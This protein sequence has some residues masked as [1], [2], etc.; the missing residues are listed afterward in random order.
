MTE[1]KIIP[2]VGFLFT[3]VINFA[4]QQNKVPLVRKLGIENRSDNDLADVQ[5][6]I[7]CEPEFA[8]GWEHHIDVIPSNQS[9]ILDVN[10]FRLS[11]R[12]LSELTEK[13]AGEIKLII[14]AREE[15][16]FQKVYPIDILA[17][18]QWVGIINLPEML[19]AFVTPNHPEI[20]KI[21]NSA[22]AI[23]NQWTGNPSFDAY[24]S[25]NPDRVKKQ[26]AA[27]YEAIA[28]LEL[29]YCSPPASFEQEGQR[30]RMCDTIFSQKLATCIDI[31]L[32]YIAC[33][34]AIGLNP[35]FIVINGH[36][37]AGCW[38]IDETF[39]DSINDDV[40][41]IK[42]RTASGIN[43]IGL[44]ESTFMNA[45][46]K[47]SFDEAM[48]AANYKLVNEDEFILF[49][50]I[51]RARYSGIKPLPQRVKTDDGWEFVEHEAE[52][53][54]SEAPEQICYCFR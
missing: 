11:S 16:I 45:G 25:L 15:V 5:V 9:L 35:L 36:A 37:F 14:S 40:S 4:I 49:L 6:K 12:F 20:S 26:M 10:D 31:S 29:I 8:S 13:I 52:K 34:E 54:I 39:P 22:S 7:E 23:L 38:L 19:A 2:K 24:Q 21:L 50:D 3:P 27:V 46:Q 17:F 47:V 51:K 18:D 28:A 32:L 30:I 48:N 42:K 53:W 41:L 33:L 44:V 43:E 1:T